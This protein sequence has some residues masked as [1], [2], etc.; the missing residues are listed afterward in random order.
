MG[1][2]EVLEVMEYEKEY[3]A[4][5]LMKL[6]NIDVNNINKPLRK[7]IYNNRLIRYFNGRCFVYK[8]VK[9]E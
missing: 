9:N 2:I 5:E 1:Q 4:K 7:L 8:R 3:T 6:T